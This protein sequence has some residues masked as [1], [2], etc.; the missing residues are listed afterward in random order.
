MSYILL[1]RDNATR[2]VRVSV[3]DRVG[4]QMLCSIKTYFLREISV[5]FVNSHYRKDHFK[6]FTICNI[7]K[8]IYFGNKHICIVN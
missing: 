2:H 3:Y 1:L 5:E 6:I 7:F 8:Y 4:N